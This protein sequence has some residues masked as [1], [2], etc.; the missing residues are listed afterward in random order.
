MSTSSDDRA[1]EFLKIADQFHLGEL[2]TEASHPVTVNLS[3]VA[4]DSVLDALR[5]LL[6][7][8]LDV[9]A[10]FREI[11]GSSRMEQIA[12][13]VLQALQAGG[14]VF[15]TGCGSTGRLSILLETMWRGFWQGRNGGSAWEN[16]VFGVMAGGDYALIKAVEGFEDY[17]QFGRRQIA[18]LGV[19]RNDVVFAITEGGET[20]F[21]IGTAWE[22]SEKGSKVYFVYNNPDDVLRATVERSRKVLDEARIEKVNLTTGPMAITGSTRMQA[23]SIQLCVLSTVLEIVVRTLTGHDAPSAATTE[24]LVELEDVHATLVSDAVV[25]SLAD[26][27]AL[28]EGA[29]RGGH[30]CNYYADGFGIDV[31]TDTTERSPTYCTPPFHKFDDPDAAESL[32]F[33]FVPATDAR[34]AW[35]HILKRR[36]RCVEWSPE[37]IQDIVPPEAR[38]RTAATLK[39]IS[40]SELERFRIDLRGMKFR[41]LGKGDCAIC[42]AAPADDRIYHGTRITIARAREAQIGVVCIGGARPSLADTTVVHVPC[43]YRR[44]LLDGP[45]RVGL[46]MLLNAHSTCVMVRFGRVVGNTMIWVVP[47]N[48]KLIDR[49]IRYIVKLTDLTY[50]EACR[51]AFEVIEYVEPRMRADQAYPPVVGIAVMRSHE[52]L[53]NDEAESRWSA[54]T[55]GLRT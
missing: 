15:F 8:D 51:L 34:A 32:A 55:P 26:L 9:L 14:R 40:T 44:L 22:G 4:Q 49:T 42:V 28:E 31:L 5:L 11:V 21:V 7:V 13:A 46:K 48:L 52:G 53:T 54:Q 27:V 33:L 12:A 37:S 35:R 3:E 36:P 39:R 17:E 2:V 18:D 6:E 43:S 25:K 38:D 47:S 20:S 30:K 50:D 41:E 19:G 16:R 23:T 1:R 24:A 10:K 45:S 29:Y